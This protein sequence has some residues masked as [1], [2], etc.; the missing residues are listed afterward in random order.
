MP[1]RRV[2]YSQRWMLKDISVAAGLLALCVVIHALAISLLMRWIAA[3]APQSVESFWHS[4]WLLIGIAWRLVLAH[5]IEVMCWAAVYQWRGAFANLEASAYF[6]I[7][8]YTTVGYGDLVPPEW[9][10]LTAGVEGLTG[11]LMCGW[12]TGFFFASV[13]RMYVSGFKKD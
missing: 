2:R 12:S 10:R 7:V 11:I 8:T 3:K 13:S 9:M 6:S 4:T 1:G 5:L